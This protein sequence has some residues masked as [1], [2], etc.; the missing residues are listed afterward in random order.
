MRN[1]ARK[2]RDTIRKT[3]TVRLNQQ[4]KPLPTFTDA[5]TWVN[6]CGKLEFTDTKSQPKTDDVDVLLKHKPK[7]DIYKAKRVLFV[8]PPKGQRMF[9]I[10]GVTS[11]AF[12][13][14]T[15]TASEAKRKQ[16]KDTLKAHPVIEEAAQDWAAITGQH[17]EQ[18]ERHLYDERANATPEEQK[19]IDRRNE[20]SAR[21][22][23]GEDYDDWMRC[24]HELRWLDE[25]RKQQQQRRSKENR[26]ALKKYRAS[27]GK[28]EPFD[29]AKTH[30]IFPT[31]IE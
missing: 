20:A 23:H 16:R 13:E 15:P 28:V 6:Y 18:I 14:Q 10:F 2:L 5:K 24:K 29:P 25:R 1:N 8:K 3:T 9:H 27:G 30:K 11:Q 21:A 4:Y 12:W 26:A 19:A 17:P 31:T 22:Y 7:Q